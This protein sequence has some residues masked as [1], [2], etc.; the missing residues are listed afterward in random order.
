MQEKFQVILEEAKILGL[1]SPVG[2]ITF[3]LAVPR[4]MGRPQKGTDVLLYSTRTSYSPSM[5]E[6]LG[7]KGSNNVTVSY[8]GKALGR[9]H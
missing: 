5:A 4:V 9:E 2:A 1:Q 8:L 6:L 3:S 7:L